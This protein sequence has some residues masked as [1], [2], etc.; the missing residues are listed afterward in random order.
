MSKRKALVLFIIYAIAM[1]LALTFGGRVSKAISSE[2]KEAL[3]RYEITDVNIGLD[4][5]GGL[6]SDSTY[7]F[8]CTPVGKY[9]ENGD[10][11]FKSSDNR[12][13]TI[14]NLGT[15]YTGNSFEGTEA[16]AEIIITST[17]DKDFIKVIPVTVKKQY[18]EE[19]YTQ[20]QILGAGYDR[21]TV[22]LGM[23]VFPYGL[24][25]KGTSY[26]ANE[27][28]IIYDEEYF[29]PSEMKGG[30][31]AIKKTEEGQKIHFT[32]RYPDGR[33]ADTIDFSIVDY[34]GVESFDEIKNLGKN[35]DVIEVVS[36][37]AIIPIIYQNGKVVQSKLQYVWSDPDLVTMNKLGRFVIKQAGDYTLTLV[38]ENGFSKSVKICVRN[39]LALPTPEEKEIADSK[40]ITI[41]EGVNKRVNFTLPDKTKFDDIIYEYDSEK[42]TVN[43]Y[44]RSFIINGSECGSTTLKVIVDDGFERIEDTYTVNVVKDTRTSTIVRRAVQYFVSKVLG[45]ICM[46]ALLGALAVN[47]LRF[48]E[49]KNGLIR[50]IEY[51]VCGLPFA[52]L[53]E[54]IQIGMDGR[55]A[56]LTDILIDMSGYLIGVLMGIAVFRFI[57][58]RKLYIWCAVDLNRQLM[59]QREAA[60]KVSVELGVSNPALTL[61]LHI[62][63]KIS[64]RIRRG[65]FKRAVKL[66]CKRFSEVEAFE[67]RPCGVEKC[68]GVVWI[69][70]SESEELLSLHEWLVKLFEEKYGVT[71]HKFDLEFAYHSS[72]FVGDEKDAEAAYEMLK[73]ISL[74]ESLI[75]SSFVIG[76]SES[77]KAG[78]Y[79]VVQS[80]RCKV[81]K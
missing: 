4:L 9:H 76:C 56:S 44:K 70:Y 33:E 34:T 78:E 23:T 39:N 52:I 67:I 30:F 58:K 24:P 64:C 71:P 43:G 2:L 68:D 7:N 80:A 59:P 18:P 28:D 74:P 75:A 42:L 73:D 31:V 66:I 12:V 11:V 17:Q 51:T 5:S 19:F 81:Q 63:L 40:T 22:Q 13:L 79:K 77:G 32:V 46:F 57:E 16:E 54:I 55:T 72:L 49:K 50:A 8:D 65:G 69:R 29:A 3:L 27:Y 37:G 6:L 21:K 25:S 47:M 26:T 10:L 20:I 53:T 48:R 60:E 41:Y 38:L 1:V 14:N 35:G 15:I 36:G 62:S 61:P 45:H